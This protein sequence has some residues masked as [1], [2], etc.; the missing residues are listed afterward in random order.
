MDLEN[1]KGQAWSLDCNIGRNVRYYRYLY[2]TAASVERLVRLAVGVLAVLGLIAAVNGAWPGASFGLAVA[3]VI[4]AI[5][6]NILPFHGYELSF[7]ILMER[8]TVLHGRLRQFESRE[9]GFLL[10][11]GEEFIRRKY[12]LEGK[13]VSKSVQERFAEL[14]GEHS[15]MEAT[16]AFDWDWLNRHCQKLER[17]SRWGPTVSTHDQETAAIEALRA[18][19]HPDRHGPPVAA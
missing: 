18:K 14:L 6:L 3:S 4:V 7:R 11:D 9:F 16:E 2:V 8:Y 12:E 17:R 13:P 1:L 10:S 5:L 15:G 19:Y